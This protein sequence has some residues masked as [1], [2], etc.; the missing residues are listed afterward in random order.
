MCNF[1]YIKRTVSA[2]FSTKESALTRYNVKY[3]YV[4]RGF[5]VAGVMVIS[6]NGVKSKC[7]LRSQYVI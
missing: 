4:A 7:N 3:M 2:W 6:T 5:W 1:Y